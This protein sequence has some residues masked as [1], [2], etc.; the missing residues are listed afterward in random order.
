MAIDGPLNISC[1]RPDT[2]SGI[3]CTIRMTSLGSKNLKAGPRVSLSGKKPTE[4]IRCACQPPMLRFVGLRTIPFHFHLIFPY[5]DPPPLIM[6]RL[7]WTAPLPLL[8]FLS[9]RSPIDPGT[10]QWHFSY[11]A[12]SDRL[13]IMYDTSAHKAVVQ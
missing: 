13:L 5:R 7:H 1:V 11:P 9:P 2:K 4:C 12:I 3:I 8:I 10:I 6:R